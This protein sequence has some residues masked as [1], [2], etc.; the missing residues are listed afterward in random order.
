MDTPPFTSH[1][2]VSMPSSAFG[3]MVRATVNL[4]RLGKRPYVALSTPGLA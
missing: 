3:S 1:L 2:D 4:A